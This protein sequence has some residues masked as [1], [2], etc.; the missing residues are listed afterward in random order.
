MSAWWAPELHTFCP[1]TTHSS[2]SRSARVARLA[3]SEPAPGSLNSWHQ[4]SSPRSM[5]GRYRA[6]CSSV[7]WPIRVGPAMPMATAN[8]PEV[9]SNCASSWRKI[10]DCTNVAPPTAEL[11]RPGDAG[12]TAVEESA[13]P[14]LALGDEDVVEVVERVGRRQLPGILLRG[15][16]LQPAADLAG[17]RPPPPGVSSK[18]IVPPLGQPPT[19]RQNGRP[20]SSAARRI[21]T[22]RA[23]STR[24]ASTSQSTMLD[25]I[26]TPSSSS[27]IPTA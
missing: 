27:T 8:R 3:R 13:L 19:G 18:S 15:I 11:H 1:F 16:G 21:T 26:R 24:R 6:R 22:S 25:I 9:T 14:G 4:T 17:G 7:P 10:I 23:M 20:T 12:P 5:G 2:P